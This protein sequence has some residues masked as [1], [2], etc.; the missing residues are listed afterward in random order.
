M[1]NSYFPKAYL[2]IAFCCL[3]WIPKGSA[4]EIYDARTL[5][6]KSAT[7]VSMEEMMQKI[8][9]GAIV[10]LGELH[11]KT[12]MQQGE[13]AVFNSLRNQGHT[14][15]VGLE[16]LKFPDQPKVDAYRSGTLSEA[17]F[18]TS[19]WGDA[20]FNFYRE[21]ILFPKADRGER[22]FA[23]NSPK[24][25]P[26]AV[27]TKGLAQLT[28][29]EKALLPPKFKL[30]R[31]SYRERFV[32]KMKGHVEGKKAMQRYFETQSVWDDTMAWKVCEAKAQSDHTLVLVV[33]QFHVEYG[34][35]LIHRIR[36]RCGKS[37]PIVSVYQYLFYN[38]E[39]PDVAQFAPSPVYGPLADYLMIVRED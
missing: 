25:L 16:F 31:K 29:E 17:D 38:D 30:G 23:I 3:C 34:D 5:Q 12:S 22:T 20:D 8:P 32:E 4:Q 13:L 2:L 37:Q 14:V 21:Q 33:G 15:D 1:F 35:S 7:K 19:S 10:V 36:A 18:K 6:P 28:K 11:N 9:K 24:E 26:L 39:T 27:K